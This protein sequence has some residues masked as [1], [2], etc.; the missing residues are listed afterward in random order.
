[1]GAQ[2]GCAVRKAQMKLPRR[3]NVEFVRKADAFLVGLGMAL[4]P[5]VAARPAD[6]VPLAC[7][8]VREVMLLLVHLYRYLVL[9]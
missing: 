3:S 9:G 1:M 5:R 4:W 2:V 8:N 7:P 6:S